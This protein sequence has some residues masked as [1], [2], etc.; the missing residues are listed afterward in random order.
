MQLEETLQGLKNAI[1]AQLTSEISLL[2]QHMNEMQQH[3]SDQLNLMREQQLQLREFVEKETEELRDAT[4]GNRD[5]AA[6][7]AEIGERL[8]GSNMD[9]SLPGSAPGESKDG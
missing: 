1:S 5:L 7:F 4:V 8:G 6:L 2:N 3:L 9:Q